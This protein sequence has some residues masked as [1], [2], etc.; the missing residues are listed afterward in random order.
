[1]YLDSAGKFVKCPDDKAGL[2]IKS[3]N[4]ALVH[5]KLPEGAIAFQIGETSQIHT[6]GILQATPHGK[7]NTSAEYY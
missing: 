6:G 3:R 1:M 2:Y 4:G 5:A 7:L